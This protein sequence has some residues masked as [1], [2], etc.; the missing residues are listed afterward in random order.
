MGHQT[1]YVALSAAD[2]GDVVQ[3]TVRVDEVTQNHASLVFELGDGL[4]VGEVVALVVGHGKRK[5]VAPLE[6]RGPGRL[7]VLDAHRHPA[8]HEAHGGIAEECSGEKMRL[9]E[10]LEA[11]ADTE[12]GTAALRELFERSHHLREAGD[13]AGPEVVAV[14][15]ATRHHHGVHALQVGVGVPQ[16]DRLGS[17]AFDRVQ[18]VAITVGARE[19]GNAYPQE[20]TSH[21]YSST[22]GL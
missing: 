2:T 3:R 19:D 1:N 20:T 14:R 6:E 18:R 8:A 12:D 21:S 15:E 9:G 13:G 17:S 11:V 5:L 22:V 16:L 10:D 4:L 7:R